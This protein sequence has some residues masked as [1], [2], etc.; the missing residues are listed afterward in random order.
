MTRAEETTTDEH[1]S[2]EP[3][4]GTACV[5]LVAGE[6][7]S[8]EQRR[9]RREVASASSRAGLS[10]L[11]TIRFSS[12]RVVSGQDSGALLPLIKPEDAKWIYTALHRY[13]VALLTLRAAY[14]RRDPSMDPAR[15]RQL[16]SLEKFVRYKAYFGMIRTTKDI[17]IHLEKFQVQRESVN[18][19]G[20]DD[21]RTLPFHIFYCF[22][23]WPELDLKSQQEKFI[24]EHGHSAHRHD[25]S[26]LSWQKPKGQAARHGGPAL[27]VARRMLEQG[28]HWDVSGRQSQKI[29]STDAVWVLKHKNSYINIY[30]NG[31]LRAPSKKYGTIRLWPK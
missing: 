7:E 17:E 31:Y 5:V 28:F 25:C 12:H 9:L 22:N 1:G 6:T 3:D 19:D 18:C 30:P 29:Y 4:I 13:D 14:V 10:V 15:D 11:K 16:V 20:V 24:K 2:A 8:P 21:P 26:G 27:R 23:D